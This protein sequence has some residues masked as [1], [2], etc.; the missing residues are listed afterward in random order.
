MVIF[1]PEFYQLSSKRTFRRHRQQG[2]RVINNLT[3]LIN[4]QK[5]PLML[6]FSTRLCNFPNPYSRNMPRNTASLGKRQGS[7]FLS[8]YRV[9]IYV[10][11][12]GSD[13]LN[14]IKWLKNFF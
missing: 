5:Y 8:Y 10:V 2:A 1:I 7:R 14:E 13:P 6:G 12:M 9:R 3:L 11:I 4:E